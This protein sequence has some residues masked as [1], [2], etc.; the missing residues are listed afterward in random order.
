M[1]CV[2]LF[3]VLFS[4]NVYSLA[5]V[6]VEMEGDEALISLIYSVD[7]PKILLHSLFLKKEKQ[8]NTFIFIECQGRLTPVHCKRMNS[9]SVD[10]VQMQKAFKRIMNWNMA[11]LAGPIYFDMPDWNRAVPETRHFA[12][13]AGPTILLFMA[14]WDTR[15][16]L[17]PVPFLTE[18]RSASWLLRQVF[19][20]SNI[21]YNE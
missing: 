17:R 16:T 9:Q 3:F 1:R 6:H 21:H 8:S 4:W 12:R 11:D 20:Y 15:S 19:Y 7:N 5:N 2:Y 18:A 10:F 14:H 13:H